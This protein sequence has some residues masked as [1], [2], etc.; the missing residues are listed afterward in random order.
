MLNVD[1]RVRKIFIPLSKTADGKYSGI[2]SD[3]SIDRDDE[4]MAK[5]LIE[6]W[7]LTKALPALS[8]HRNEMRSLSGIWTNFRLIEKAGRTALMADLNFLKSNPHT[9][10]MEAVVKEAEELGHSVGVSISAIPTKFK[11][12]DMKKDGLTLEWLKA[13]LV[14]AS[15]LP[16]QSNRNAYMV[17]AKSFGVDKAL[18]NLNNN[19][20][21]V[22]S[23]EKIE[24]DVNMTEDKVKQ[25]EVKEDEVKEEK[26][27]AESKSID[28]EKKVDKLTKGLETL[29][30][31]VSK[32]VEMNS[33]P[34]K[35]EKTHDRASDLKNNYEEPAVKKEVNKFNKKAE[36]SLF[37]GLAASAG[38]FDYIQ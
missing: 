27:E 8:D 1:D 32:M 4:R 3:D 21:T 28:L 15:I 22:E 30:G 6:S 13:E 24:G 29:T 38:K 2:L 12:Y 34:A 18:K 37:D 10:W 25:P 36:Y 16:I 7:V 11:E 9:A 5:S 14:E 20:P 31:A 17:V 26:Q 33:K 35:V 19:P 23:V